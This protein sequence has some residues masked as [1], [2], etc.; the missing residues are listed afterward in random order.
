M[1]DNDKDV[2]V[3]T[4]RDGD[5]YPESVLKAQDGK[6]IPLTLRPGGPVIG[7][8]TLKYNP[9]KQGLEARFRVDDPKVAEALRGTM[10][11]SIDK[12]ES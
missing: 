3:Q 10:P 11:Y 5:I 1:A 7:E 2:F 9:E 8:A 4:W 12:K 6:V